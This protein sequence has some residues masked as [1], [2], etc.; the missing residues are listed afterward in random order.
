METGRICAPA[1]RLYQLMSEKGHRGSR[2]VDML[3]GIRTI[4]F[5]LEAMQ[6]R[7][8]FW[9]TATSA[10]LLSHFGHASIWT[11]ID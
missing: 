6:H 2:F 3:T 1:D 11:Q 9:S 5:R 8:Y 7:Q 10:H 4:F